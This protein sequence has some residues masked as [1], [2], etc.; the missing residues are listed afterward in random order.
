MKYLIKKILTES[1]DLTKMGEV[2]TRFNDPDEPEVQQ[3]LK[4]FNYDMANV[5]HYLDSKG[6]G[7]DFLQNLRERN[8]KFTTAYLNFSLFINTNPATI[9]A[10]QT[11]MLSQ[12][13]GL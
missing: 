12:N 9:P 7:D 6:Y 4:L 8:K 11:K 1:T 5:Y 13:C 3:Y 10:V 2:L